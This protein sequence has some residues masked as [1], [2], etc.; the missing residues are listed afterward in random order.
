MFQKDDIE[1]SQTLHHCISLEDQE[2]NKEECG[3]PLPPKTKFA[4]KDTCERQNMIKRESQYN[5]FVRPV[6]ERRGMGTIMRWFYSIRKCCYPM[7]INSPSS[8][9]VDVSSQQLHI[10][11]HDDKAYSNHL[12]SLERTTSWMYTSSFTTVFLSFAIVY[13][14]IITLFAFF[15][16]LLNL[17]YLNHLQRECMDGWNATIA[18]YMN[19]ETTFSLSWTTFSTVGYG[20]VSPTLNFQC[21]GLELLC[22]IEA[23]VGLL[24]VAFCGSIVFAKI[25][26]LHS[27]ARVTFS[28]I[29]CLEYDNTKRTQS[30]DQNKKNQYQIHERRESYPFIEFRIVNDDANNPKRSAIFDASVQCVLITYKQIDTSTKSDISLREMGSYNSATA[31]NANATATD[32]VNTTQLDFTRQSIDQDD[33]TINNERIPVT[34][35]HVTRL[36]VEPNTN[37]FFRRVWYVRHK[38]D[39]D[40]PLLT[41]DAKERIISNHGRWPIEFNDHNVIRESLVP[42]RQIVVTFSGTSIVTMEHVFAYASYIFDDIYIGW[43]FARVFYSLSTSDD[44]STNDSSRYLDEALVH[45]DRTLI[46]D[47]VPQSGGGNEP[48]DTTADIGAVTGTNAIITGTTS[49]A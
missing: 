24:Y 47:I 5:I 29:L 25:V 12:C 27:R 32:A 21:I 11:P 1:D 3:S 48:I 16:F 36:K 4:Q 34:K 43:Q 20:H 30:D 6:G 37:P 13:I 41:P 2:V 26:L 23:F 33:A 44:T 18:G 39:V 38:L 40:S 42:F 10:P 45:I 22:S 15:I 35:K 7:Q 9:A 8:F 49:T 28:S 14:S 46:H 31:N 19:Y 17:F